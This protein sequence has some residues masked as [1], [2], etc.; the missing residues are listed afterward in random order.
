MSGNFKRGFVLAALA[1]A[2]AGCGQPSNTGGDGHKA[3]A[4][5]EFERGP[6][7]GRML[8][9]GDFAVEMTIFESGVP[10]EFHIYAYQGGASVK[11]ADVTLSVVLKRLGGKTDK[12]AFAPVG[13][14][15]RGNGVVT[16]PHSFD[17]EVTAV[18]A[19]KTHKWSYASY[20]GRTTIGDKAAA[21]AGVT[22]E[23]AGPATVK[24]TVSLLG[25]IELAPGAKAELRAR[26]PGRVVSV[27][28]NV[29]DKVDA[30]QMLARIE[31]NESLQTY[32]M[33]TPVSGVVLSRDVNA[34]D[35]TD[36]RVLFVVGDVSKLA[37]QFHVFDRDAAQVKAGQIMRVASLDGKTVAETTIAT[38]S[39]MKDPATQTVIARAR[40][41]NTAGAF[42][43]GTSVKGDVVVDEA[44]VDLA[45]K[46]EA[47]QPFRDFEVVYAKVGETYEVRMLEIGRRSPEWTEIVGGIDPGEVYVVAN[48]Y[49]IK[50]DI[51]K[52]GAS[53]DH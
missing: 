32:S 23:A 24:L 16:E 3:A 7:R 9:S 42:L 29:G 19:G 1:A 44:K 46:T 49:L 17:V 51:E 22:T 47:I 43:P 38:I 52:S 37:A 28:K 15:L 2:L 53:H 25:T 45:V 50:A 35:V 6:H 18:H 36:D 11:P 30:G 20:E 31:S 12:F 48:S 8:R 14:Y 5:S 40:L 34:G 10:P 13:D 27:A 39:P 41:D 21:D 4:V 26:F 33:T